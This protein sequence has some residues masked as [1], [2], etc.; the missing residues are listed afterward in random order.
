MTRPYSGG[1][2]IVAMGRTSSFPSSGN[3]GYIGYRDIPFQSVT[4]DVLRSG[5][6]NWALILPIGR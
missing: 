4:F 6:T 2:M 1:T 3:E 5:P